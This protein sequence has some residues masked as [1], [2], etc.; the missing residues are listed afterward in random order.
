MVLI[1]AVDLV[2]MKQVIQRID[3]M[4]VVKKVSGLRMRRLRKEQIAHVHGHGCRDQT[5][6]RR[7]DGLTTDGGSKTAC[8]GSSTNVPDAEQWCQEETGAPIIQQSS[9][10]NGSLCSTEQK[11]LVTKT[12]RGKSWMIGKCKVSVMGLFRYGWV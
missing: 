4:K 5:H 7:A 3:R 1:Q 9:E 2:K 11:H 6:V 8:C 12:T 10:G